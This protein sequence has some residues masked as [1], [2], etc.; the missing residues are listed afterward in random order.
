MFCSIAVFSIVSVILNWSN[1]QYFCFYCIFDQMNA[2]LVSTSMEPRTS[3][4]EK[5]IVAMN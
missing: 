2:A 3:H 1:L 5:Y 4:L